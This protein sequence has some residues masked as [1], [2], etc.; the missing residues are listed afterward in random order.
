[1]I[2]IEILAS[3]NPWWEDPKKLFSDQKL[4]E[5]N[6]IDP[7]LNVLGTSAQTEGYVFVA[8]NQLIIG[9]RQ[10]GKT[11]YIKLIIKDLL[12]F[13]KAYP[14]NVLYFSC[15]SLSRKEDILELVNLFDTYSDRSKP[16]YIFLDEVSF[17]EDW[18][19]AVLSMFN[20][21][22]LSDKVIYITGSSSLS[23]QKERFPGRD[24]ER[25]IF[26]PLNF[27]EYFER[28]TGKK[29]LS[30]LPDIA[31]AGAVYKSA[32]DLIPNL[33]ELN[34]LLESYAFVTG[35]FILSAYYQNSRYYMANRARPDPLAGLYEVYR[36]GIIGEIA[37]LERSERTFK[38]MLSSIVQKYGSRISANS[39]AK[40][41][42]IGSNRTVEAYLELMEKLFLIRVMYGRRNDKPIYR[43]SK[44][45][46]LIDPFLYRV[47]KLYS[48]G[49]NMLGEQEKPHVIEGIVG[50][51]LIRHAKESDEIN[52]MHTS[53]GKEIDF[54]YRDLGIEVK[55]GTG[56]FKDLKGS[57]GYV[58]TKNDP[59]AVSGGKATIPISMFLYML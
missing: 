50:E 19:V 4:Q 54:L 20:S 22:F 40:E 49:A 5:A 52:F 24:I 55:Y 1:M 31:D 13:Q 2:N 6:A 38:E 58:L 33:P 39:I 9:P 57:K 10:V 28:K 7:S 11:T 44:K 53:Q 34:R 32:V 51:H 26:Y 29:L 56:S 45:I 48:T 27:R 43:G 18:S 30:K 23:M 16:R 42:S 46:Y 14:R 3:Q 59:P 15:E 35:G 12:F 17:I 41:N 36:D 47:L 25:R 21:G 37:D 8:K